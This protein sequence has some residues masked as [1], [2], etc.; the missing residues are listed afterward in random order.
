[1]EFYFRKINVS[2]SKLMDEKYR[3]F[4]KKVDDTKKYNLDKDSLFTEFNEHI[5]NG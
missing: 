2:F 5:L 4:V 1:M 3:Y